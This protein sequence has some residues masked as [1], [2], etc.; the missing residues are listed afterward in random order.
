MTGHWSALLRPG[1]RTLAGLALAAAA[2]GLV[3]ILTRPQPTEPVLVA[4]GPLPAGIPLDTLPIEVRQMN[5]AT[6][7]VVGDTA[8]GLAGWTLAA[9]VAEGEPLLSSLLR[10]P[11][12]TTYPSVLAVSVEAAHAVLGDIQTG[13]SLDVYVT[14]DDGTSPPATSLVA[15]GIFVVSAGLGSDGLGGEDMVN[16]LVAVD[17]TLATKLAWAMA[18]GELDLVRV[19]R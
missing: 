13:D 14:V 10:A 16:L 15:S 7:L 6:G 1:R 17:K 5:D 12:R 3:L 19:S 18:T 4:A 8:D 9:P 2:G 11:E